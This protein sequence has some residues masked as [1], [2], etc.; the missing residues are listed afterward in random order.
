MR[1]YII[2][3]RAVNVSGKNIIKMEELRRILSEYN[4]QNIQT[5]IQSGN[6]VL[7]SDLSDFDVKEKIQAIIAERLGLEVET[8]VTQKELLTAILKQNPFPKELP[9]NKVFVTF[10]HQ[11]I[12]QELIDQ[13]QKSD[14]GEEKYHID[15]LQLYFYLP[16]GAAKA[17]LSNNFFEHKLKV[18][19]TTRNINTILKL[20]EM[21]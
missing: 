14:F 3:L 20:L 6:I 10:F 11:K 13:L 12:Q 16:E 4:F 8:F 7:S 5:Y 9:A 18:K 19:A 17:K 15:G 1:N 21:S 2:L